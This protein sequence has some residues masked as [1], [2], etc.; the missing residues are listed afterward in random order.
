V[1]FSFYN[2]EL[3]RMSVTY[4]W[5]RVGG[6]TDEDMVQAVSAIYGRT[7]TKTLLSL[8]QPDKED[9]KVIA[10]WQDSQYSLDLLQSSY[11]HTFKMVLVSKRLDALARAAMAEAARLDEQEAPRREIERQKKQAEES[12]AELEKVR[13]VNK[14][15]FHP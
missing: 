13:L 12:R 1:L 11:P 14:A 4:D 10:R 15:T 9:E 6:L 8:P 5:Y 2:G 3:F 7:E